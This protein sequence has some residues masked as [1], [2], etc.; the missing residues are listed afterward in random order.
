DS[1]NDHIVEGK[2]Y[3][4]L[5]YEVKEELDSYSLSIIIL[6]EEKDQEIEEMFLRLQNGMSLNSAEKRNA[7]DG[8]MRDFLRDVTLTHK[9]FTSSV[10]FENKRY[11]HDEYA[12]QMMQI[13][14]LDG[15]TVI[16]ATRLGQM[17]NNGKNFK[18]NSAEAAKFKRVLN[19]LSRAFPEKSPE[20]T[21]AN[22]VSLYTLAS[23]LLP[24]YTLTPR[25]K[26]FG[27]WFRGFEKRRDEYNE[28][29]Q[30]DDDEIHAYSLAVSQ[31]TGSL[32][33]QRIRRDIL[34]NYLLASIPD[35]ALLDEQRL[36]TEEQRLV[37]FRKASGK[38]RNPDN[39][40]ECAK[41]CTKDNFHADHI[42]P[43]SKGG[44]TTVSNGQLLCPSCNWKKLDKMPTAS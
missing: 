12:V 27:E 11:A 32:P 13:E 24:I 5:H 14:M 25:G 40:P 1:V 41:I 3:E 16:S 38:C 7:I 22:L 31:G 42:I 43:H 33:S 2:Y 18:K 9:L 44:K 15:P 17:Y 20:L 23:E 36:F 30:Q 34:R 28:N 10:W 29:P 19:F 39:N 4:D 6:E 37:I 26:D 21:K 35:L 8:N